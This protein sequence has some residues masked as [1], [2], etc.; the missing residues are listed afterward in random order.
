M[1]AIS[2]AAVDWL[3]RTGSAH[4]SFASTMFVQTTILFAIVG[5]MD[6]ILLRR[7]RVVIRYAVWSLLL[8]KLMLPVSL[9]GPLGVLRIC[10]YV[11]M[12]PDSPTRSAELQVSTGRSISKPAI[13]ATGTSIG[14]DHC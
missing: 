2:S 12:R 10:D 13:A 7:R 6:L 8:I 5:V 9:P 3:N 1:P 4:W 14:A 11:S